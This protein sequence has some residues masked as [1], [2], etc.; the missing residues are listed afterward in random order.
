MILDNFRLGGRVA[1]VTG[2]NRGLGLGIAAALAEAGADIVSVQRA[3]AADE[4]AGRV[5]AAG[6]ALEIA[7]IDVGAPGAAPR[8][9]AAALARFGRADILVNNAGIQKRHPAHEFPIEDFDAVM[10]VNFRAVWLFCQTFGAHMLTHGGGKIINV[11]SL[12]AFQGGITVPAYAAA[13]H[14][15][16]GI[17]KAL[18]NEWSARGINVNA[19]A[20]GYM[21]TEMNVALRADAA[22]NAQISARI[23]AGR[24]GRLEDIGGLAV[25]LASPAADYMHGQVIAIDGGWMAR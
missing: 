2:G 5:R 3:A 12:L 13:K 18:C 19:I 24:W 7:Q 9:L 25:Y 8:A 4:L 21:D 1:I 15:V 20:P 11:S 23:P 16:A 22:R 10:N 14:A 6:R 17:T